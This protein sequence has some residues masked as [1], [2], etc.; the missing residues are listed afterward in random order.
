MDY[1]IAAIQ[2]HPPRVHIPLLTKVQVGFPAQSFVDSFED[3]LNLAG[4]LAATDDK[5]VGEAAQPPDV[6]HDDVCGLLVGGCFYRL[7]SYLRCFQE[8]LPS[9]FGLGVCLN[10]TIFCDR[11]DVSYFDS[12]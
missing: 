9:F 2:E 8:G 5:V 10:Y 11:R 4:A 3:G 1:D 7:A 12:L 6:Q